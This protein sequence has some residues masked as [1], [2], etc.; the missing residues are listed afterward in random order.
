MTLC[1]SSEKVPDCDYVA[2]WCLY[3]VKNDFVVLLAHSRCLTE[4]LSHGLGAR[5]I[6]QMPGASVDAPQRT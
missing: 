6:P 2:M 5:K 4:R 1:D 3:S